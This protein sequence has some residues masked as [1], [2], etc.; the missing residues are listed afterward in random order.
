M[1][2][3]EKH[4]HERG[5]GICGRCGG[6]W[7][8]DCLVYAHGAKKPPLCMPC[9]MYAGGVRSS[10]TRPA[11]PRRELKARLKAAKAAEKARD[12]APAEQPERADEAAAVEVAPPPPP[13]VS[14]WETPW[15]EDRVPTL[16]D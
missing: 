3:C 16:A 2:T 9:A 10:A 12:D 7:C 14:D 4:P 1:D 11:M 15:W 5:A 8:G 6:S 13:V